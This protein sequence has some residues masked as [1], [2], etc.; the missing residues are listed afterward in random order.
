[1]IL[2]K[3]VSSPFK[4]LLSQKDAFDD[5]I[6]IAHEV[7]HSLRKKSKKEGWI[8]IKLDMKKAYDMLEW[9]FILAT[10]TL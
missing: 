9:N 7:F 10:L 4:W 3:K 5:N 1:M 8:A 2:E 6:L